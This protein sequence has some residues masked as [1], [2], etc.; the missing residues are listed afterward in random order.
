VENKL[1]PDVNISEVIDFGTS[2]F[3]EQDDLQEFFVD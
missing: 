3:E 2:E 1:E